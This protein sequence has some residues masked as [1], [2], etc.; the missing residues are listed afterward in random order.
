LDKKVASW[1]RLSS[2]LILR[3]PKKNI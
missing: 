1:K 3:E 2:L